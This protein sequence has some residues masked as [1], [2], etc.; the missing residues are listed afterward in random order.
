[1]SEAEK[2][3]RGKIESAVL[4]SQEEDFET[5]I[6]LLITLSIIAS[7]AYGSRYQVYRPNREFLQTH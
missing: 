3:M 7:D 6:S 5:P 4:R 2:K 1:M